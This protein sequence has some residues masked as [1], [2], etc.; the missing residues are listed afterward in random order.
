[1]K[2]VI[3]TGAGGYVGIPLCQ[4]LLAK[5]YEVIA[6]DRYFF[7]IEKMGVVSGN[8]SLAILKDDIRY[9]NS[10]VFKNVYAVIDLA[11]LSNDATAEIDPQLT[12]SINYKGSE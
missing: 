9:C 1:M 10:S 2:K 5:N 8:P 11:G 3:V 12:I 6:L 7:G 4:A